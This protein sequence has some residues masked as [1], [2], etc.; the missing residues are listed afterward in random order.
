MAD[1]PPHTYVLEREGPQ[2]LPERRAWWIPR[3]Q[4]LQAEKNT[5]KSVIRDEAPCENRAVVHVQK[6]GRLA[7]RRGARAFR[8]TRHLLIVEAS[9]LASAAKSRRD[10]F[11]LQWPATSAA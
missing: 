9:A 3:G 1:V 10:R 6:P 11:N 4:T 2:G 5:D 7:E 8:T